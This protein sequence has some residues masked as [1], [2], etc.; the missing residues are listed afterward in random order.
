MQALDVDS[1][2]RL[3]GISPRSLADK[4]YRARLGL[5]ARRVGR[6]LV[7]AEEDCVRILRRGKEPFP[8]RERRATD[9]L[10]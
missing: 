5:A 8:V 10:G 2:A 4:R 7:F 3:L 1:A 6:R 9:K